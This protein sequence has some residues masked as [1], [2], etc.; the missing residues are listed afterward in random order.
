MTVIDARGLTVI[1][2]ERPI[3]S[4]VS[5]SLRAGEMLALLGPNGAGK[6]TLFR[7]LTQEIKANHGDISFLGQTLGTWSQ[8]ALS[9]RRAVMA[10]H[11]EVTFPFTVEQIVALGRLPHL[12]ESLAQRDR[13]IAESLAAADVSH[14]RGRMMTT[15][16]G[17]EQQRVHFARALTQLAHAPSPS[18][19]FLDE[20]TSSLDFAHQHLLLRGVRHH[21]DDGGAAIVVLHDL[22]LAMQYA[23]SALLLNRGCE[24]AVGEPESV[25]QPQWIGQAYGVAASRLTDP[26]LNRTW[27][28]VDGALATHSLSESQSA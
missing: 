12:K 25:L 4:D 13:I 5:L 17:G 23:D 26:V 20:P 21:C 10:Q 2:G 15:L 27:I 18:V 24:V 14:L 22:N 28:V 6:S 7:C 9:Q 19:L 11:V 3:L 8:Q 16:S 1:R